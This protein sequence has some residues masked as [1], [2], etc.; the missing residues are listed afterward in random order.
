MRKELFVDVP[1]VLEVARE[2]HAVAY[3]DL[4]NSCTAGSGTHLR[5]VDSG[6][7]A[8]AAVARCGLVHRS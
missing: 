4:A 7:Q 3:A 2:S 5:V 8:T 1:L 6:S